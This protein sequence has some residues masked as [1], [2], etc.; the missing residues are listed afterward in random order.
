MA[1]LNQHD[2]APSTNIPKQDISPSS[3]ALN[4]NKGRAIL[5]SQSDTGGAEA[6]LTDQRLSAQQLTGE[7]TAPVS[8]NSRDFAHERA[9]EEAVS[10]QT[11]QTNQLSQDTT[12]VIN[13]DQ[14]QKQLLN[15][16]QKGSGNVNSQNQILNPD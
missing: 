6:A 16:D 5:E 10:A 3:S 11:N 13:N 2:Q 7:E 4:V 9:S 1:S 14:L 8:A 12:T 15:Q